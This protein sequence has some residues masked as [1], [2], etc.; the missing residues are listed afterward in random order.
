MRM[1]RRLLKRTLLAPFL[2]LPLLSCR[3]KKPSAREVA[4]LLESPGGLPEKSVIVPRALR[5][6]TGADGGSGPLDDRALFAVN[7]VL[8]RM[9][10]Q[11][12]V[13]IGDVS[14]PI[15]DGYEHL[16]TIAP[17]ADALSGG[18]VHSA[19]SST[20]D[21]ESDG[22]TSGWRAL[23]AR[24][25]LVNVDAIHDSDSPTEKLR[26]GYALAYIDYRYV[27][28]DI[29]AALDQ[30]SAEFEELEL[31]QQRSVAAVARLN[32]T[33]IYHGRAYFTHDRSGAWIVTGTECPRC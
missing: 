5:L 8:A 31:A 23:L 18:N 20:S 3:E 32:S 16:L 7:P 22:P 33:R 11:R 15:G 1:V 28:T 26:L 30:G 9:H 24:P 19:D 27:P 13:T 14:S 17:T 6:R 29:G 25:K 10:Q 21:G 4:V 2:L 12:L